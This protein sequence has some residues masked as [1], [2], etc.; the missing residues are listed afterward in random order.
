MKLEVGMEWDCA[1]ILEMEFFF[2]FFG[3]KGWGMFPDT[4][5]F[6]VGVAIGPSRSHF[7]HSFDCT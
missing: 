2:F 1:E 4:P 6:E 7:P 3:F 5:R